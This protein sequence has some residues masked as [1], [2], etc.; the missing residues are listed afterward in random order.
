[1]RIDSSHSLLSCQKILQR[2]EDLSTLIKYNAKQK[3]IGQ[4]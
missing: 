1:M 3:S 2:N 4:G